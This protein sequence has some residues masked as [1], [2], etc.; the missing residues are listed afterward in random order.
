ME[1]VI[2]KV[3]KKF[4]D[5]WLKKECKEDLK[6]I[7]KTTYQETAQIIF[8]DIE[9]TCKVDKG[10]GYWKKLKKKHGVK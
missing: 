3:L 9:K 2:K 7:I 4:K 1:K 6:E 10:M 5:E 8:E